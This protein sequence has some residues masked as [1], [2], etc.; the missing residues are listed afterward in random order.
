[1][2]NFIYRIVNDT[3]DGGCFALLSSYT[4]KLPAFKNDAK[5][6]KQKSEWL[7]ESGNNVVLFYHVA[8]IVAAWFQYAV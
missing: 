4:S 8:C 5:K 1:M 3:W 2:P 6:Y 7:L